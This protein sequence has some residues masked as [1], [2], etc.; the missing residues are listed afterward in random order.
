MRPETDTVPCRCPYCSEPITL[1]IDCSEPEQQYIEDW[2][3][4]RHHLR[5]RGR[6]PEVWLCDENDA[7]GPF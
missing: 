2:A 3:D 4:D 6:P 7:G 1:V 5:V